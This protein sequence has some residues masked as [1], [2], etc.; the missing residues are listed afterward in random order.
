MRY[1]DLISNPQKELGCLLE[2]ANLNYEP[3]AINFRD[4]IQYQLAGNRLRKQQDRKEIKQDLSWQAGLTSFDLLIFHIF[5]GW[6]NR[7]YQKRF[8]K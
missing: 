2:K 4:A 3:R 8:I 6:L 5:A 1:E 7:F